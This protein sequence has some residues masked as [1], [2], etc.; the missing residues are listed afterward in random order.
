MDH[1][2]G[3]TAVSGALHLNDMLEQLF[4]NYYLFLV[5]LRL[6][7]YTAY[8]QERRVVVTDVLS[9]VLSIDEALHGFVWRYKSRS[10]CIKFA[11]FI[12]RPKSL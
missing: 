6:S 5:G 11:H 3:Q 1:E 12:F 8:C 4:I 9:G 10:F 2:D 7:R